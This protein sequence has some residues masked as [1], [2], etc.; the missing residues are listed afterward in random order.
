MSEPRQPHEQSERPEQSESSERPEHSDPRGEPGAAGPTSHVGAPGAGPT[1]PPP[2]PSRKGLSTGAKVALGCGAVTLVGL[3][4]MVILAV[5]GGMFVKREAENLAGGIEAHAEASETLD[6]LRDEHPFRVPDDGVVSR[7]QAETFFAVTDDAWERMEGW[8]E[9]LGDLSRRLERRGGEARIG[10]V[11]AG[12]RGMVGFGRTRL[13]L[14]ETLA[15]HDIS[16]GEYV[17][18]GLSLVKAYEKLMDPEAAPVPEGNLE[19]A[20]RHRDRL[21][22]FADDDDGEPDPGIVLWLASIW[23]MSDGATWQALGLDTLMRSAR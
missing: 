17:W 10:D 18:T 20:R 15:D 21:A 3:V 11:A 2:P 6:R 5:V 9:E 14:A 8:A 12:I 19:L 23:G 1:T 7:G 4:V 13:V 22:E 16:N